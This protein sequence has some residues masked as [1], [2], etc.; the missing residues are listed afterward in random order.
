MAF[1]EDGGKSFG[2][3]I[4]VEG[5]AAA[6]FVDVLLLKDGAALVSWRARRSDG[7]EQDLRLA[8]VSE[9]RGVL[10]QTLVPVGEFPEYP[11]EIPLLQRV[12]DQSLLPGPMPAHTGC[13]W[14][15]CR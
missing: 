13:A 14:C 15:A 8:R 1:S 9:A 10:A 3:P 5:E 2:S 7:P 11:S 12:G 4:T 6:G